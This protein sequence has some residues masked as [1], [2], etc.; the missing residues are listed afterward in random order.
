MH[1]LLLIWNTIN[2]LGANH[3]RSLATE[4]N[5]KKA[6]FNIKTG[7]SS[8]AQQWSTISQKHLP[9]INTGC[10]KLEIHAM[11]CVLCE[12]NNNPWGGKSLSNHYKLGIPVRNLLSNTWVERHVEGRKRSKQ[13]LLNLIS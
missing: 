1:K 10:S 7:L 5:T 4:L 9:G 8:S 6:V 2:Y 3:L 13:S 12:G 11:P